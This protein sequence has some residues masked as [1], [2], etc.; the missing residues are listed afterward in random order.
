MI[1]RLLLITTIS[2]LILSCVS[3]QTN[4]V[5]GV[6]G[7]KDYGVVYMLPKSVLQIKVN[8][9]KI[10]YHPGEFSQYAERYLHMSNSKS[11]AEVKWALKSIEVNSIGVNNPEETFFI[12]MK[13]KSVAPLV[14]LTPEGLI[15]SINCPYTPKPKV[16]SSHT[17][18][19]KSIDPREFLTEEILLAN[20]TAKMAELVAR[21]IYTIRE[22]RNALLRG[23]AD[24]MPQ[25]GKQLKLMLDNLEEQER[26][27][28]SMFT[29]KVSKEEKSYIFQL[30]PK[31][32]NKEVV[33][34]FST[35]YGVLEKDNLAG[36]PIYLDMKDQ[37]I[38]PE[39]EEKGKKKT[40]GIAY[41]VPGKAEVTVYTSS[42]PIY[43][44][45]L[46]ITQFGTQEFLAPTLFNKKSTI[47]VVFD[48]NTGG[49]LNIDQED[50]N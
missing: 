10:T 17:T 39:N 22:S 40:V 5:S 43:K 42:T 28:T 44:G 29:G 36:E 11:E 9:E 6:M 19:V 48:P 50:T 14:E 47:Q 46:L 1:K 3:A 20:S 21:E 30:E 41:N 18:S 15:K 16:E 24:N 34:R 26:A 38:I 31:E 33:F 25:D 12:K 37:K 32:Y 49:L 35:V 2:T 4:V 13:D 27:M 45:E 8:A 7:G 23:Q